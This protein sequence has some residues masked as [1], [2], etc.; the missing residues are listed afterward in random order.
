MVA[1]IIDSTEGG[2][3]EVHK[4]YDQGETYA[5]MA[6]EYKRKYDLTVSAA[7]FSYRRSTRG[8]ERRRRT[9]DDALFPWMVKDEHRWHRH[10]VMLRL[11]AR[12]RRFGAETMRDRDVRDL[13]S[14][15]E[16][17]KE[18]DVV[19]HYDPNTED[20]FLLVPREPRDSDI[21]RQPSDVAW[22]RRRTHT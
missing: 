16:R 15:R 11:E 22:S 20:G 13:M 4:W 12:H 21:V 2:E 7:I 5:W 10:L 19:I 8:W 18:A 3:L 14:F 1:S 6:K 17:L 9:R